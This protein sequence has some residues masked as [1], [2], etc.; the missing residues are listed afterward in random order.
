MPLFSDVSCEA[1]PEIHNAY[2]TSPQQQRYLPGA[3][4]QYECDSHFQITAVNYVTCSN[5]QW[6]QTPTCKGRNL[7]F[8]LAP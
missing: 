8:H 1:P 6:L 3:R 5:G 2:I 7:C 4:V